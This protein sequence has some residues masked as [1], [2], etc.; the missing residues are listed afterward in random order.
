MPDNS[1]SLKYNDQIHELLLVEVKP[2]DN[3]TEHANLIKMANIL[4][5]SIDCLY[6][7]G[8]SKIDIT[9]YG[10]VVE[11]NNESQH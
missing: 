6:K 9:F 3:L 7:S 8:W 5:H 1:V 2:P 10:L 11:G 4:T